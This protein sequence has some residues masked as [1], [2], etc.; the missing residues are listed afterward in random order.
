MKIYN[1][2]CQDRHT[3][4]TATPF[5]DVENAKEYVRSEVKKYQER[6]PDDTKELTPPDGWLMYVEFSCEGDCFWI[7][8]HEIELFEGGK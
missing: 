5:S 6:Y 3:D 4:T 8:E 2:L 1:V 7:T